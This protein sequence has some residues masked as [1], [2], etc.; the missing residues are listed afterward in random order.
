MKYK[1]MLLAMITSVFYNIPLNKTIFE[2][3]KV[4]FLIKVGRQFPATVIL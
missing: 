3:N 4:P 1:H 2:H